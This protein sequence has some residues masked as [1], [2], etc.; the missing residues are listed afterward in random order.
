MKVTVPLEV[1][2]VP[3]PD[4]VPEVLEVVGVV[5]VVEVVG[6]VVPA[7]PEVLVVDV[8]VPAVVVAVEPDP[9]GVVDPLDLVEAA[10]NVTGVPVRR[11]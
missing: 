2:D 10:V 6:V 4:A 3:L 9:A 1:V 5:V 11:P 7:V 8:D